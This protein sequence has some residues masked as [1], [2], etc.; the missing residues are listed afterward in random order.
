ML[1]EVVVSTTRSEKPTFDTPQ[2]VSVISHSVIMASPFERIEDI[3]RDVV[4]YENHSHYGNQKGGVSSHFSVRGV[5]RNRTLMLLDGVPL[6]DNFSNTITWVAWGLIP[7]ETI[8]RIEIVRGPTSATYGSEGLGG[9]VHIITKKPS[10]KKEGSASFTAGSADTYKGSGYYSQK[11]G[12]WGWL[13]SGGYETSDG[14]YMV[15]SDILDDEDYD[16]VK[17]RYRDA[18]K[19]FGKLTYDS[20]ERT[21]IDFSALHY[22]HEMGK[23]WDYFYDIARL[24]QYR[25]TLTHQGKQMDWSGMAFYNRAVKTANIADTST[26]ASLIR[27]EK[28]PDNRVWGMSLQNTARLRDRFFITSGL[29][30]KHVFMD[31]DEDHINS[32]RDF[33]AS[34]RQKTIAPFVDLTGNFLNNRLIVNAGLR[35]SN[36]R[37]YDGRSWDT[38]PPKRDAFDI[39]FE[40]DTWDDFS[41]K[42]GVVYH[43][44]QRTALRASVGTGFRAPSTFDLYKVHS[45]SNWSI[46]WANPELEP[47]RIVTWDINAERYFFDHLWINLAYYN[48]RATDFIG[49]RTVDSYYIGSREYRETM[50]DNISEVDIHGVEAVM[51]YDFGH[52]LAADLNYTYNISKIEKDEVNASLE[53]NYVSGSPRHKYRA[54]MTYRNP[55][56]ISGS[57]SLRYDAHIYSDNEN[58][59]MRDDYMSVDLSLWRKFNRLTL[60]LNI[61]NLTDETEYVEDGTLYYGSVTYE[62]F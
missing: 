62:F 22:N 56:V 55:S 60:R 33:G 1:D 15:D 21:H 35:Y 46:R 50:Y 2:S 36:I 13:V 49:T 58:T 7:K 41:P 6:N 3:L 14:L 18:G 47:E 57:L 45:R 10:D 43:P 16:Y 38:A 5:G 32:D 54:R 24:D 42:A 27:K 4:G 28:F 34:G 8:E 52:G 20:G 40:E 29:D 19:V 11:S 61:E 9:V 12:N 51:K 39:R 17:R 23:G 31:Y 59:E 37:N 25:L 26:H 53:G 48:S 30:Y 44:D